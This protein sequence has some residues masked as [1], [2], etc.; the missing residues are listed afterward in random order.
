MSEPTKPANPSNFPGRKFVVIDEV[1]EMT[2]AM[3]EAVLA[4]KGNEFS[5][6]TNQQNPTCPTPFDM[7]R[8]KTESLPG[9]NDN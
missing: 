9:E 6:Q 2:P 3:W 7:F 5:I 8:A 1:V 4:I